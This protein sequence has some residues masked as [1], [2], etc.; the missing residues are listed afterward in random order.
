[1]LVN[2]EDDPHRDYRLVIAGDGPSADDLRASLAG[3]APSRTLFV[4]H[5]DHDQLVALYHAA[6]IFI[7]PNPR[8]PFGIAPLEAMAAGLP[9]VA[10]ASGGVLTYANPENAWL[11]DNTPE[12]FAEG[13]R[14]VHADPNTC[15]R[16]TAVAR[17]TAA[18]FSWPRVTANYFH[19]YDHFHACFAREGFRNPS[20]TRVAVSRSDASEAC[21]A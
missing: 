16:K 2:L 1:M 5:C 18:Q 6:D 20:A 17:A 19:L 13:I 4:G 14:R 8:E 11:V 9:L 3:V 10:P 15:R 21:S 7:H 12:A